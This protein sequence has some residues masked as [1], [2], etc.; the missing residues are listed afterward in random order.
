MNAVR[1]KLEIRAKKAGLFLLGKTKALLKQAG[2]TSSAPAAASIPQ[3]DVSESNLQAHEFRDWR[4]YFSAKLSGRGLEIGPLHRPML[5]HEDMEVDYI[6]RCTVA[7]LRRHYPELNELP[8]VE[9]TI[10]GDA[11]TM[12]VVPDRA[13]DFLIAAH[14]IE[15]M[16]NPVLSVKHWL[17]VLKPGGR[18]Y[19][20]VPDKRETFDKKRVRTTLAHLILD[21]QH[22]SAERDFEHYVDYAIHVHD[23]S[24]EE[25]IVEAE[26]LRTTNYSIHYHVFMPTDVLQFLK[27]F[28]TSVAPL[29]IEEG[30][31]MSPGSDEFHFLL[32]KL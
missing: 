18:L 20:L 3:A 24:G 21:Y 16:K 15:H 28:S 4:K 17:R 2:E 10:I 5:R 12:D 7:E 9:P 11:E 14:V 27:W 30:P 22:P 29:E 19:M 26:R 32:R 1:E 13:Y 6:D 25:A 8:L 31:V 23:K